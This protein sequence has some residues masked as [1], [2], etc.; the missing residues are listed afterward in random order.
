MILISTK[1]VRNRIFANFV[2]ISSFSRNQRLI[3]VAQ[4]SP[5]LKVIFIINCSWL[6]TFNFKRYTDWL[7]W[8][9]ICKF[10]NLFLSHLVV[11]KMY[12]KFLNMNLWSHETIWW[13]F[14]RF[15]KTTHTCARNKIKILFPM[16]I[17]ERHFLVLGVVGRHLEGDDL[18]L[19]ES[20]GHGEHLAPMSSLVNVPLGRIGVRHSCGITSND[21]KRCPRGHSGLCVPLNFC[22]SWKHKCYRIRIVFLFI[23]VVHYQWRITLY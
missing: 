18:E 2:K 12:L 20:R 17:K 16:R 11:F 9:Y 4:N 6:T 5:C 21:V 13:K 15:C 8:K 1:Q 14:S 3:V 7:R 19:C 10:I 23:Q 22:G